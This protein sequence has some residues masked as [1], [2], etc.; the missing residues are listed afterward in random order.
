MYPFKFKPIFKEKIWGGSQ[1]KTILNKAIQ[2]T[3][4][5][6]SWEISG[7]EGNV[8]VVEN[9]NL[10]GEDLRSLIRKFKGDLLGQKIYQRFGNE[11]PL[12]IK[13]LDA[14]QNLSIQVHP[15]DKLAQKRGEGMGK[16]EMW[17]ILE[18]KPE[19]VLVSGF[20]RPL[21]QDLYLDYF[22]NGKLEEILNIEQ[23]QKGDVFFIPAGR[24]HTIGKGILLA[25]IQQT[26]DTTY[27]IYDYNRLDANGKQRELHTQEALGAID[28]EFYQQ[29][30]TQYCSNQ[31][32]ALLADCPYFT[33]N[34]LI[35]EEPLNKN[36]QA[37][38]S[39]V[40]YI[41]VEGAIKIQYGQNAVSLKLGES[42]LIPATLSKLKLTPMGKVN[43]ILEVFVKFGHK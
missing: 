7:L 35:I 4:C 31:K 24:V 14:N 30:K 8:S 32:Q 21:N 10:A 18:A 12:L 20:N 34:L 42:V 23:V 13:F 19:A 6:E 38:D 41:C 26:S 17:Y 5:G 39:F 25:E 22:E 43:K 40:I 27:R 9:G 29:Y 2:S 1:L 11:F 33:S 37:I 15:D 3:S 28:Y 36:Y 16:T